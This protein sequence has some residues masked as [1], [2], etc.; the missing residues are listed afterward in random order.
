MFAVFLV[1]KRSLEHLISMV[2]VVR[3]HWLSTMV[4]CFFLLL[5]YSFLAL[6]LCLSPCDVACDAAFGVWCG[7]AHQCLHSKRSRVHR[8][9]V[10]MV[11]L[12]VEQIERSMGSHLIVLNISRQKISRSRIACRQFMFKVRPRQNEIDHHSYSFGIQSVVYLR[13]SM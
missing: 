6:S 11:A 12:V 1:K 5:A 8:H 4:S 10:H 3:S 7:V 2:C 9:H 13:R